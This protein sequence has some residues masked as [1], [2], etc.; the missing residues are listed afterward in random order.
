MLPS[1]S[2][3]VIS[4]EIIIGDILVEACFAMRILAPESVITSMLLLG[5][6]GG[7]SIKLIKL[8]LGLIFSILFIT[9]SNRHLKPFLFLTSLFL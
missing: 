1:G 6:S 4:F 2:L 5:V 7:V 3:A 9:A 8:I